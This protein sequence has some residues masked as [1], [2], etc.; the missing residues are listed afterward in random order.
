M[1][2]HIAPETCTNK[3]YVGGTSVNLCECTPPCPPYVLAPEKV[4]AWL[5]IPAKWKKTLLEIANEAEGLSLYDVEMLSGM[6]GLED[7]KEN[8]KRLSCIYCASEHRVT[9]IK[10]INQEWQAKGF[11]TCERCACHIAKISKKRA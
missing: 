1:Q 6:I 2:E 5:L 8:G 9:L 10:S 11:A 7:R 4:A 3:R